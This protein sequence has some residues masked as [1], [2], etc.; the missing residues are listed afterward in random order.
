M[1]KLKRIMLLHDDICRYEGILSNARSSVDF[2]LCKGIYMLPSDLQLKISLRQGFSDKLEV[3][4]RKTAGKVKAA[5]KTASHEVT[6]H[7]PH[8]Q[9]LTLH[10]QTIIFGE[11]K[12]KFS[13]IIL[14]VFR[15]VIPEKQDSFSPNRRFYEDFYRYLLNQCW[16]T[17]SELTCL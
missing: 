15:R 4:A 10:K 12:A 7:I 1:G 5:E 11:S 2:S 13:A 17:E 6:P 14:Q 3:R 16:L 9:K 8:P